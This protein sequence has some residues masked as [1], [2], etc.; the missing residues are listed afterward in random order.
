MF[1]NV[2]LAFRTVIFW[3]IFSEWLEIFGKLS[4][5]LSLVCLHNKQNN[6]MAASRYEISLLMFNL[7]S[8]SFATLTCGISSQTLEEKF[9]IY[10]YR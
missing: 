10:V 5:T 6:Y 1:R 7:M 2:G 8:H 3:K 4:E 9:H